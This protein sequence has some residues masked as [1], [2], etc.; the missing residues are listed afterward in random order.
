MNV[1]YPGESHSCLPQAVQIRAN[2]LRRVQ[3]LPFFQIRHFHVHDQRD[4]VA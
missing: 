1:G 4:V 3:C 2:G